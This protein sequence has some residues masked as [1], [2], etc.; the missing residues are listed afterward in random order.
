M[1]EGGAETYLNLYLK[2]V[3]RRGKR[4]YSHCSRALFSVFIPL[5]HSRGWVRCADL[6]RK[7]HYCLSPKKRNKKQP[8]KEEMAMKNAS[9]NG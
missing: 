8:E 4:K 1:V 6:C 7:S 9:G 3:I 2:S 5:H